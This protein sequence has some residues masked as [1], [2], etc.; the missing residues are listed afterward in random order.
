LET[1]HI[2]PKAWNPVE[3]V[4]DFSLQQ[5]SES[6]GYEGNSFHDGFELGWHRYLENFK[7]VR[8]S[9][10]SMAIHRQLEDRRA[11]FQPDLPNALEL[12]DCPALCYVGEL[13]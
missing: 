11:G 4:E 2:H 7:I 12:E 10:F 13:E 9:D 1:T 5:V 8:L 3:R 6:N